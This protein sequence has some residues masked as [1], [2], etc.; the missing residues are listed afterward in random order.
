MPSS[1]PV[2]DR[3]RPRRSSH[4]VA[5]VFGILA[6]GSIA[7]LTPS[8]PLSAQ[9]VTWETLSVS[10][11]FSV[12]AAVRG[13]AP[14]PAVKLE[15]LVG[16]SGGAG[17]QFVYHGTPAL[18]VTSTSPG[19]RSI[20]TTQVIDFVD[21]GVQS[22]FNGRCCSNNA[23]G[24]TDDT[25]LHSTTNFAAGTSAEVL[26]GTPQLADPWSVFGEHAPAA[27]GGEEPL[28]I[29]SFVSWVLSGEGSPFFSELDPEGTISFRRIAVGSDFPAP[30]LPIH[31]IDGPVGTAPAFQLDLSDC[32]GVSSSWHFT[33]DRSDPLD[34]SYV[35]CV[36]TNGS[37][38]VKRVE[39]DPDQVT[40]IPLAAGVGTTSAIFAYL[41][42]A[43]CPIA[44][45]TVVGTVIPRQSLGTTTFFATY[46]S[47][48]GAV[49]GTSQVTLPGARANHQAFFCRPR[50]DIAT[51]VYHGTGQ[52][53]TTTTDTF[54]V[55]AGPASLAPPSGGGTPLLV[56]RVTESR[57]T[58]WADA[59]PDTLYTPSGQKIELDYRGL[60]PVAEIH[61]G[62]SANVRYGGIPIPIFFHNFESGD[63]RFFS[64][65]S[66]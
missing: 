48:A 11:P 65:T 6:A 46:L 28:G 43:A 38:V 20:D 37:L 21:F 34:E 58:D 44:T 17:N 14:A 47:A 56:R 25:T 60:E 55:E 13:V 12:T 45:G 7:F 30:G 4:L 5:R 42:V 39:L 52:N 54:V 50:G 19:L 26:I 18:A 63:L 2:F 35:A 23:L 16:F 8:S 59:F 22:A 9:F 31:T 49:V 36:K 41:H 40:E 53:A 3:R 33:M 66:P 1:A 32:L 57:R 24:L 29:G 27:Q 51:F 62:T 64:T 10:N 61:A 15:G